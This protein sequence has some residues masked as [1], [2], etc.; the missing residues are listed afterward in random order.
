M[1][2]S[3]NSISSSSAKGST[4]KPRT[5]LP[6]MLT[7]AEKKR[8][9]TASITASNQSFELP[10]EETPVD[11]DWKK[12]GDQTVAAL[13]IAAKLTLNASRKA[14][15]AVKKQID[16]L[17]E[18]RSN[19]SAAPNEDD[20]F[21]FNYADDTFSYQETKQAKVEKPVPPKPEVPKVKSTEPEIVQNQIYETEFEEAPTPIRPKRERKV[22]APRVKRE[23]KPR[24]FKVAIRALT[25]LLLLATIGVGGFYAYPKLNPPT[26]ESSSNQMNVTEDIQPTEDCPVKSTDFNLESKGYKICYATRDF[27]PNLT[28]EQILRVINAIEAS[29]KACIAQKVPAPAGCPISETRY[30]KVQSI[31]W[32]QVQTTKPVFT[33]QDANYVYATVQYAA[34]AK[35]IYLKNGKRTSFNYPEGSE[36]TVQVETTDNSFNVIWQ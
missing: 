33:A 21:T 6:W 19:N 31:R 32:I 2:N 35:G 9:G 7:D 30:T 14:S 18:N 17:Q 23:R 26:Q 28:N 15:Q 5:T 8:F 11:V 16:N 12:M 3:E 1:E 22:R 29:F 24:N 36:K 34:N 27:R 4:N 13:N 25:A 10:A 20:S